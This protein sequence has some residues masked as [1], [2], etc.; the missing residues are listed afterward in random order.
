M[1]NRHFIH[2]LVDAKLGQHNDPRQMRVIQRQRIG[3][4]AQHPG[5]KRMRI[6]MGEKGDGVGQP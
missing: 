1:E 3:F 4:P 2:I 5:D 6:F